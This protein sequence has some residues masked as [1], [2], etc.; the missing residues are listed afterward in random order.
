MSLAAVAIVVSGLSALFTASNMLVSFATYRRAKPKVEVNA[1]WLQVVEEEWEENIG[2]F[3]VGLSNRGGHAVKVSDLGLEIEF[4]EGVPDAIDPFAE[5]TTTLKVVKGDVEEAIEA[6]G[7]VQW[8]VW[9]DSYSEVFTPFIER[10]R[11]QVTLSDGRTVKS[12]WLI[13]GT[14]Y[15]ITHDTVLDMAEAYLKNIHPEMDSSMKQLTFDD[16]KEEQGE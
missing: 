1:N 6:F 12:K 10:V 14:R 15:V 13:K 9:P 4:V 11:V 5:Y 16:L 8:E 3:W 2:F 7:G